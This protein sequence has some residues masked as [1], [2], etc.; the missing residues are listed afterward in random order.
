MI[1]TKGRRHQLSLFD[2]V[3]TKNIIEF[4]TIRRFSQS[5]ID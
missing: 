3:T 1:E 4:N 2:Y 5:V